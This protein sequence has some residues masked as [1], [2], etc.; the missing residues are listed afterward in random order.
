MV[1]EPGAVYAIKNVS[2]MNRLVV[3]TGGLEP[4]TPALRGTCLACILLLNIRINGAFV[5]SIAG[6]CI[7]VQDRVP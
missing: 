6:Q 7:T 4:P 1:R 5:A 2:E 3:A